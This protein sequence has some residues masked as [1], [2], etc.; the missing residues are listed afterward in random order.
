MSMTLEYRQTS[1]PAAVN[2]C[3]ILHHWKG[4]DLAFIRLPVQTTATNCPIQWVFR[5]HPPHL[6]S[7]HTLYIWCSDH[8]LYIW[9]QTTPLTLSLNGGRC[10]LPKSK[11]RLLPHQ[12]PANCQHRC[13]PTTQADIRGAPKPNCDNNYHHKFTNHTMQKKVSGFFVFDWNVQR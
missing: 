4:G 5:P 10:I 11:L 13:E 3:H 12:L 6:V 7:E 8:T 1:C 2:F 9:F